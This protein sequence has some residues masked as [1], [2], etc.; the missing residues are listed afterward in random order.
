MRHHIQYST[1]SDTGWTPQVPYRD[2]PR[3]IPLRPALSIKKLS[4]NFGQYVLTLKCHCG[5]SRITRPDALARFMGWDAELEHVVKRMRCSRCGERR[6][7][8][9]IR[10]ETKRDG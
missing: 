6:C 7:S 1:R 4:D 9:S 8:F 2:N 5:H 10:S 3:M